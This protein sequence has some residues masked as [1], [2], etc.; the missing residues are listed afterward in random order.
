MTETME[1]VGPEPEDGG[2]PP[3]K[4]TEEDERV[5]LRVSLFFDGTGNNRVNTTQRLQASE[6]YKTHGKADN[7][8]ANDYSNVSRLEERVGRTA[9]GYDYYISVYTE[10]IGTID[11]Q[12]DDTFPGKAMGR[13][14]NGVFA[15]VEKGILKAL[16]RISKTVPSGA[17]ITKLTVDTFGF[18]RGAAAARWCIHRVLN[19]T[20]PTRARKKPL[21][22]AVTALAHPVEALDVK[23][24]GLFDTVSA[25][26][27]P[28]DISDVGELKLNAVRHAQ[29]VLQ[30]AAAEE[31]RKNFSL[32]NIDSAGGKG[33]Q[34]FLPGAH[35]D[36]GG[37]YVDGDNE[38]KMLITGSD[39]T[40]IAEFLREN[41][42]YQGDEL[43]HRQIVTE[44]MVNESVQV[45]RTGISNEYS[46]IPLR[47]MADFATEQGLP[48]D[49]RLY[50][51]FDPVNV[52]EE[53]K[54]RIEAYAAAKGSGSKASD[55]ETNDPSLRSLRH[56]FLHISAGTSVGMSMRT[57]G[58]YEAVRPTRK[59]F[60]G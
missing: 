45:N 42:W 52:P 20:G 49:P 24:V 37:A 47:L 8:Y 59:V 51:Y 17:T 25:L 16:S 15:K 18:S 53:V 38:Q 56:D 46:F 34:L 1:G 48:I 7:S 54:G 3:P 2:D 29:A 39:S 43:V 6:I 9:A 40:G 27:L 44:S 33:R 55:W 12:G 22:A 10:G 58:K 13:G 11:L 35:S 50:L 14:P 5:T 30:L 28:V 36:I 41:G 19:E 60:S 4:E 26:G 23:A 21:N 57:T 32:T 31:Y